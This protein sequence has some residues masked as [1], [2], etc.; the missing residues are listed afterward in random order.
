MPPDR[1]DGALHSS[2]PDVDIEHATWV[3]DASSPHHPCPTDRQASAS[4]EIQRLYDADQADRQA[5]TPDWSKIAEADVRRRVRIAEL[6]AVGCV[7]SAQDFYSAALIYQHGDVPEHYLLAYL[8]ASRAAAL[9]DDFSDAAEGALDRYLVSTGHK[10]LF[11]TQAAY[12]PD[13][14]TCLSQVETSF[15]D[16]ERIHLTGTGL[17]GRIEWARSLSRGKSACSKSPWECSAQLKPTPKG[18]VPGAW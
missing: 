13:G 18:S 7:Q 10:Q 11:A 16:A 17:D 5:A 1:L 12:G 6:F 8:F 3:I 15:P 9:G 4:A 14:C 2:A